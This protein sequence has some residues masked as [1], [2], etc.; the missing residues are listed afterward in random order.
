MDFIR[1]CD[2][3]KLKEAWHR[4]RYGSIGCFIFPLQLGVIS[5]TD[6][7]GL[8]QIYSLLVLLTR[9]LRKKGDLQIKAYKLD[10]VL[11]RKIIKR[12]VLEGGH[13][14]DYARGGAVL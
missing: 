13:P 14:T 8:G 4:F 10:F 6:A 7:S 5:A 2:R 1:F 11:V 3:A 12:G 9:L